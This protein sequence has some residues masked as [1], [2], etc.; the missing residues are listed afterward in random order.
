MN[1]FLQTVSQIFNAL[2]LIV[3]GDNTANEHIAV[4]QAHWLLSWLMV[5]AGSFIYM[6]YLPNAFVNSTTG[7]IISETVVYTD[8]KSANMISLISSLFVGYLIVYL[9]EKP[10]QYSGSVLRYIVFQNWIFLAFI[11]SFLPLYATT[12]GYSSSNPFAALSLFI[13]IFSVFLTYKALKLLLSIDGLKALMLLVVLIVFEL[14]LKYK[15]DDWFGLLVK[16]SHA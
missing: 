4:S 5:I 15:I 13:F 12:G 3:K 9:F 10:F 6:L 11:I 14:T 2:V 7:K 8:F 16:P 1:F